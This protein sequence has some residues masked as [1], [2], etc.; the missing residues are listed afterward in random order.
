M[1]PINIS[2]V[3]YVLTFILCWAACSASS[4]TN[5]CTCG[6]SKIDIAVIGVFYFFGSSDL[7]LDLDPSARQHL[8][9][10]DCLEVKR[11]IIRTAP[12]WIV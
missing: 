9:Y 8:S 7:Y 10:G 6:R 5:D 11:N 1:G 3:F 12:C 4:S 2:L